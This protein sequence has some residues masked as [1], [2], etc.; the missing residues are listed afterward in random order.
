VLKSYLI[1]IPS[2]IRRLYFRFVINRRGRTC[3]YNQ[4]FPFQSALAAGC[5]SISSSTKIIS[6]RSR[7]FLPSNEMTTSR[8]GSLMPRPFVLTSQSTGARWAGA[9]VV[10]SV[11]KSNDARS[12]SPFMDTSA[13]VAGYN[14]NKTRAAEQ[15]RFAVGCRTKLALLS[16]RNVQTE[17]L[18]YD[19]RT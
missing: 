2:R 8:Y 5:G 14:K 1:G 4:I 7:V 19:A 11:V 13:P 3:P 10:A 12:E 15:R 18:F 17:R 9:S 16:S 6:A